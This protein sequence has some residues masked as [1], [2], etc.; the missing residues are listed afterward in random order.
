MANSLPDGRRF[1]DDGV[2]A[3]RG[4][5]VLD[6]STFTPGP[7]GTQ[8]LADL[9][10]TVLKI[11][12]PGS[13]D[14]ERDTV[15]EYF[16]AYN[17]GKFSLELDLKNVEDRQVCL[18]LGAEADIVVEGFRPGVVDR[19]GVGY[20]HM[21]EVNP[22]VIYASLSG[23]GQSGPLR[24][25]YDLPADV[26]RVDDLLGAARSTRGKPW[27]RA[28]LVSRARSVTLR[29]WNGRPAG[30]ARPHARPARLARPAPRPARPARRPRPGR[31]PRPPPPGAAR[32]PP[33]AR[34]APAVGCRRGCRRT[35]RYG[36]GSGAASSARSRSSW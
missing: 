32:P 14:P 35:P 25:E 19:L 23:Y 11:E 18:D 5:R 9:G 10:A 2:T 26:G 1:I 33:C 34:P 12:R 7:F 22:D 29:L 30:P 4:V 15:P 6:L 13:G 16:H 28:A 3:L 27:F 24:D 8:I 20:A 31:R 21:V 36:A 17:R